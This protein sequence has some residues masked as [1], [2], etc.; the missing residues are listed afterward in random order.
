MSFPQY[1]WKNGIADDALPG[2]SVSLSLLPTFRGRY[3]RFDTRV[4]GQQA[5]TTQREVQNAF[6]SLLADTD[7]VNDLKNLHVNR[8]VQHSLQLL[9]RRSPFFRVVPMVNA[10]PPVK[11]RYVHYLIGSWPH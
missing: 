3:V 5:V 10:G 8:L 4:L 1:G 7:S 9:D 11:K 2:A 6:K